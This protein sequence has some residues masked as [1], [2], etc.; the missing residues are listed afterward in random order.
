MA[1][2][3][4]SVALSSFEGPRP[5]LFLRDVQEDLRLLGLPDPPCRVFLKRKNWSRR[6]RCGLWPFQN[7]HAYGVARCFMQGQRE[8]IEA[9]HLMEPVCQLMEQRGQI[10]V[11]DNRFRNG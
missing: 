11:R 3:L 4:N 7:M 5:A 8:V 1:R 9:H 10:A 2:T 6:K